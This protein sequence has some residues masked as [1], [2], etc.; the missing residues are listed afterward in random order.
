M[1]K[2]TQKLSSPLKKEIISLWD[3]YKTNLTSEARFVNQIN[4]LAVLLQALLYQKKDKNL[5]IGWIWEWAFEKCDCPFILEF[6]EIIKGK[7]YKKSL[8]QRALFK[9]LG[10]KYA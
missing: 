5:P 1:E 7:F 8:I 9:F 6:L 10:S 3:E 4:V 2:L